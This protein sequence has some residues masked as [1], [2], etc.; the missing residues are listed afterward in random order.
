MNELQKRILTSLIIAPIFIILSYLGSYIFIFLLALLYII[1]IIEINKISNSKKKKLFNYILI[2][3]FLIGLYFVRGKTDQEFIIFLW[4]SFVTF[5]SDIGGYLFGKLFKGKRLTTISPNKTYAGSLGSILLSLLSINVV[6]LL[7]TT[8]FSGNNFINISLKN[9]LIVLFLSL[10]CQFGD[11]YF[12]YLK[13]LTLTKDTGNILPGHG[14]ILD[15]IDGMIFVFI[16]ALILKF[17]NL[18]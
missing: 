5:L 15:R 16:A 8:F 6:N 10:T 7:V 13:R 12:S 17:S 18:I 2:T 11:L 4:V 3:L 9:Y 1:S 14:G